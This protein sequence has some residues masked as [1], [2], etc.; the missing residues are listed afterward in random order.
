MTIKIANFGLSYD[1]FS[2][3]YCCIRSHKS[4]PVPLRW[5]APE[6][7]R[8]SRVSVYSDIWSY[9]VRTRARGLG[10]LLSRKHVFGSLGLKLELG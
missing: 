1:R 4:M 7:I 5:L 3:D 10:G 8:H 2:E 9:G 6:T